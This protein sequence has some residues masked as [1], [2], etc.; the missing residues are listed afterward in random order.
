MIAITPLV[1]WFEALAL[2][3]EFKFFPGPR[4]PEFGKGDRI[5]VVTP[6]AGPGETLEGI[7]ENSSFQVALIGREH[8]AADL[9]AAAFQVDSLLLF[10][11]YPADLWGTFVQSVSRVGGQPSPI[12]EDEHDRVRYV[13]S[14][15]AHETVER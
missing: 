5:G 9:Q 7:G 1:A 13:C 4:V 14:Y 6:L 2:P 15:I 10:G 11:D 12:Q 3:V 8:A